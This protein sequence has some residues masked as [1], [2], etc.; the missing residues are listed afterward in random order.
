MNLHP[1]KKIF[2][3]LG[4]R[5]QASI[6][7]LIFPAAS[8]AK[9]LDFTMFLGYTMFNHGTN[10]SV[11]FWVKHSIQKVGPSWY[12]YFLPVISEESTNLYL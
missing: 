7:C 10:L 2:P 1:A 5:N 4:D 3:G 9:T 11:F 8:A 6:L 12:F